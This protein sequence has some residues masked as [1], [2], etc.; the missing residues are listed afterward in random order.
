MDA[1]DYGIYKWIDYVANVWK[2]VE[3]DGLKIESYKIAK[4]PE[5]VTRFPSAIN[6]VPGTKKKYSVSGDAT[7]NYAGKTQ[8][9]IV[10]SKMMNKIPLV[11]KFVDPIYAAAAAHIT[12][13]GN[14]FN[15]YV[16]DVDLVTMSWGGEVEHFG[17]E[18]TW[19]LQ[20]TQTGKFTVSA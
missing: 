5:I 4:I 20:E 6:F 12:L 15:F 7:G 16:T 13:W 8:F 11:M 18:A 1:L 2:E 10:S 19:T 9:H 3:V 17:L 14:V